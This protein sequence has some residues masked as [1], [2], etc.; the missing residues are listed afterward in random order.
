MI[1]PRDSFT[2]KHIW[3]DLKSKYTQTQGAWKKN[4]KWWSFHQLNNDFMV[5]RNILL[6]NC[7]YVEILKFQIFGRPIIFPSQGI[8]EAQFLLYALQ[9]NPV[10]HPTFNNRKYFQFKDITGISLHW[11]NFF[12][13]NQWIITPL[14]YGRYSHIESHKTV[15]KEY[16]AIATISITVSFITVTNMGTFP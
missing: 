15:R 14:S 5:L 12:Q 11:L 3:Y 4:C 2:K 8:V 7:L 6:K 10:F 13:I 9:T 1:S 16:F